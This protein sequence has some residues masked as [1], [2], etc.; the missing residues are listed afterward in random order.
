MPVINMKIKTLI[1]EILPY[2]S[3]RRTATKKTLLKIFSVLNINCDFLEKIGNGKVSLSSGGRPCDFTIDQKLVILTTRHCMIIADLIGDCCKKVGI[4]Y[5][6]IIEKPKCGFSDQQHIVICPQM[7]TMLPEKYVAFQMEQSVSSRWFTDEYFEQLKKAEA[8]LDYSLVN[9]KFLEEHGIELSKIF[10][11][12]IDF[13]YNFN[14]KYRDIKKEYDVVFY[15]DNECERRQKIL[16]RLSDKFNVRVVN[17]L[18]GEELYKELAKARVIV[19]IHYYEGALLET[20]RLYECIS[21]GTSAIVSEKSVDFDEHDELRHFV[22]FVDIDDVDALERTVSK[23]IEQPSLLTETLSN[24]DIQRSEKKHTAFD[25]YFLRFL[26]ATDNINFDNFYDNAADYIRFDNDFWCLGLPEYMERK[27]SFVS[28]NKYGINYFPGLRHF[29]GWVGCGMSYKFMLRKA[30]EMDL[31]SVTICEDDV[32]FCDDFLQ[33]MATIRKYLHKTSNWD[34]FSGLIA[35][36]NPNTVISKVDDYDGIRFI[37]LDKMTSTVFNVYN[38]QFLEKLEEWDSD[39]RDA[40][41]NTIDRF[42]ENLGN[43]II[44]T[45]N[46]FLVL[47]KDELTST[48]W[49]FTNDTYNSMI[50]QSNRKISN[51]IDE[52]LQQRD[53]LK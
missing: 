33:K 12:P 15:G 7:F 13:R 47:C 37:T 3:R 14:R 32:L 21:L 27:Q 10:Y 1:N 43:T 6:I 16:K 36:V 19:N 38:K 35:D 25:Y 53:D 41:I 40:S 2:G 17:N 31:E 24:M 30:K 29:L 50:C 51:K 18:F 46:P 11:L 42:I 45:T 8:V 22:E 48:L 49:G 28:I 4:E 44:I 26:L 9:I 20:T 23:Y 5:E 52:F 39:N 34:L